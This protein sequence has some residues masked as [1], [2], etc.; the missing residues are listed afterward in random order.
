MSEWISA[1]ERLPKSNM[2]VL[3]IVNPGISTGERW[4]YISYYDEEFR[5]WKDCD[6]KFVE[7]WMEIPEMPKE[8]EA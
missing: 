7:Y 4:M 8:D 3:V 1:R 2:T 5:L 6:A